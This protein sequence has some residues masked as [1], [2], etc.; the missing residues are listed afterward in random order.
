MTYTTM[1]ACIAR[2]RREKELTQEALANKLGVTNQAVSKWESDA[3]F[4]DI[5][6]LPQLADAL[7]LTL[8]ALFGRETDESARLE[9]L[10][11][12]ANTVIDELPWPDDDDL[13]AVLYRGHTLLMPQDG[14]N[15]FDRYDKLRDKLELH[16]SGN[17]HD[18]SA[19]FDVICDRATEISGSVKA[20]GDVSCGDVHGAVNVGGD[21]SCACINSTTAGMR[22]GGDVNCAGALCCSDIG[23]DATCNGGSIS[24]GEVGGDVQ[25]GGDV[26]C[27]GV[28]GDVKC[29]GA[30]TCG[31]IGGDVEC[32]GAISC[33]NIGGDVECDDAIRC[34]GSI[35]GDVEAES[36]TCSRIRGDVRADTVTTQKD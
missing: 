32:D 36:V 16:F 18:I 9:Q 6:L 2:A 5:T 15:R 21:L 22:I 17:V 14:T 10:P 33:G 34:S 13:H 20:G 23:G 28:G 24:C 27:G 25:A 4:P 7:G 3:C 26:Y 29:G 8:D 19:A 31:N 12:G 1:G 11:N 35:G 30:M